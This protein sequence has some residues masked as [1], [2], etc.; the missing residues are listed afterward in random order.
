MDPVPADRSPDG[1][2]FISARIIG[3]Q[4]LRRNGSGHENLF[5]RGARKEGIMKFPLLIKATKIGDKPN[6]HQCVL[7]K[8]RLRYEQPTRQS[9]W[10]QQVL[11]S[12]VRRILIA[13]VAVHG[14]SN[15]GQWFMTR[16]T[17]KTFRV[18]CCIFGP[19]ST[20]ILRKWAGVK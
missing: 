7:L 18:G 8:T 4:N 20:R 13:G 17:S 14:S 10:L 2:W 1:F 15:D 19:T 11:L 5:A 9:Q 16:P 3:N 6:G 12:D